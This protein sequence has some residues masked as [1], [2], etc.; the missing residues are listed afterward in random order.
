MLPVNV[1]RHP[2]LTRRVPLRGPPQ[3]CFHPVGDDVR[4]TD[5]RWV[6]IMKDSWFVAMISTY[7]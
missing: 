2:P 4:S 3:V 6:L 7:F 1:L 5:P